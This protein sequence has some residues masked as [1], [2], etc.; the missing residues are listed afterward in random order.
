MSENDCLRVL[1]L[2][3]TKHGNI[4]R[5]I[6]G[7]IDMNGIYVYIITQFLQIKKVLLHLRPREPSLRRVN[8][9]EEALWFDRYASRGDQK[10][11]NTRGLVSN[12]EQPFLIGV[13]P[14][15]PSYVHLLCLWPRPPL[16]AYLPRVSLQCRSMVT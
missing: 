6:S 15:G 5:R 7:E 2:D 13:G 11:G 12:L 3:N 14:C 10:N 1:C 9:K 4:Q 16:P 8:T